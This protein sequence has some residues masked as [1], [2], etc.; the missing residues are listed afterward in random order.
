MDKRRKK[1]VKQQGKRSTMDMPIVKLYLDFISTPEAF[2]AGQK[3]NLKQFMAEN[4]IGSY[5]TLEKYESVVGFQEE[6]LRRKND[7]IAQE[8]IEMLELGKA[9]LKLVSTKHMLKREVVDNKCNIQTI[10]EEQA[11][12]V[13]ACERLIQ[14]GGGEIADT[15]N[16]NSM[17]DIAREIANMK[18]VKA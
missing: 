16:I 14:L 15:V 1:A 2:K 12:S 10:E 11:P 18:E 5:H 13:K 17:A 8:K 6:L 4:N 9:G 3:K 7:Y